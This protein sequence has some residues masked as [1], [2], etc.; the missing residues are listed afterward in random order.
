MDATSQGC[1]IFLDTIYQNGEIF[2]ITKKIL[3]YH[4]IYKNS[5]IYSTGA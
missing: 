3:N 4:K 2:Q 1:Q 5:I